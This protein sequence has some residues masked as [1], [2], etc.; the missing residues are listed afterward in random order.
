[1]FNQ[2]VPDWLIGVW[3]RL[4]L[5]ED[6]HYDTTTQVIWIQTSS[7]FAD[8]RIPAGRA[9]FITGDRTRQEKKHKLPDQHYLNSNRLENSADLENSLAS[10]SPQQAS[11]LCQQEGFAGITQFAN[12]VC[13]W[14][15]ALDYAPFTGEADQGTLHWEGD[16]LIEI[17]PEGAYKEEWQRMA[18]GPTATMTATNGAAWEKWLVVCGDYFIYMCDRRQHL[19]ANTTLKD[20]L[21]FLPNGKL[22]LASQQYLNCE[23]SLGRIQPG[24]VAWEIQQSTLPWK[25]GDRLW[26]LEDWNR[27]DRNPKDFSI[28]KARNQIIQTDGD[29]Q[30]IWNVQEWGNL[31]QLLSPQLAI[32]LS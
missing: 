32:A 29:R 21:S 4:S 11:L 26:N 20:L 13:E 17:G 2:T 30:T 18:T 14:H 10:L 31:Q 9:A 24:N 22:D 16:T 6:G 23:V 28:D 5:E 15:R 25:E 27:E 1:M 8:I 3:K 12:G 19:P 7:G